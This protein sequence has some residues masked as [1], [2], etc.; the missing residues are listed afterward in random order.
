VTAVVYKKL[1]SPVAD[2]FPGYF[3]VLVVGGF[4]PAVSFFPTARPFINWRAFSLTLFFILLVSL[5]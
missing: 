5:L 4:V 1:F 3:T 2:G